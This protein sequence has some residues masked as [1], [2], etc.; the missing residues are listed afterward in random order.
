MNQ[1]YF[2]VSK[3]DYIHVLSKLNDTNTFMLKNSF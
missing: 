3:M 1:I 2:L